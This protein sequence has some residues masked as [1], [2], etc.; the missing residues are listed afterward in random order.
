MA[1]TDCGGISDHPPCRTNATPLRLNQTVSAVFRCGSS[2]L[3]AV[4]LVC[5][6]HTP[7]RVDGRAKTLENYSV[8]GRS[9]YSPQDIA[10]SDPASAWG[11]LAT[12]SPPPRNCYIR[13]AAHPDLDG[14]PLDLSPPPPKDV[15]HGHACSWKGGKKGV[16]TTLDDV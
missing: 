3:L 8:G 4:L 13:P 6:L 9:S 7:Y 2:G 12:S 16:K 11:A 15:I 14:H 10:R 5:L 1:S